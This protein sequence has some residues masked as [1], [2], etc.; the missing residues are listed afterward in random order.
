MSCEIWRERRT[1][2]SAS[3]VLYLV[4][5]LSP[6]Q[7]VLCLSFSA[8][9]VLH[10]VHLLPVS[11]IL[12]VFCLPFSASL[13]F[14]F[15]R[16]LSFI[17]C[18]LHLSFWDVT[19]ACIDRPCSPC[20][21]LFRT[22]VVCR[23]RSAK[24]SCVF[25]VLVFRVCSDIVIFFASRV[26]EGSV[27]LDTPRG[28]NPRTSTPISLLK[29]ISRTNHF[30]YKKNPFSPSPIKFISHLCPTLLCIISHCFVLH[31]SVL[32]YIAV[33][34]II[35]QCFVLH[36][37]V[38]YHIAVFSSQCF[39]SY[40]SVLFYIALFCIISQCF[41]LH[42]CRSCATLPQFSA[43]RCCICNQLLVVRPFSSPLKKRSRR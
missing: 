40:R 33:F 27:I 9:F 8:C 25:H 26:S 12:C 24:A 23:V 22:T 6:I 30:E 7:C 38:L 11:F 19:Q 13:V 41:V 17:L 1:Q 14:H 15:V 2:F 36:R 31:R 16:L 18:V 37:S 10:L 20:S 35:S 42:R 4:R 29:I 43:Q 34:C 5:L 32:Y 21:L 28:L 3:S 39:V